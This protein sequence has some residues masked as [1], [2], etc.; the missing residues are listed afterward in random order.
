MDLEYHGLIAKECVFALTDTGR[1]TVVLET[2]VV[3]DQVRAVKRAAS[4]VDYMMAIAFGSSLPFLLSSCLLLVRVLL[5]LSY[6]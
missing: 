3:M 1:V 4:I 5:I 6:L 2:A